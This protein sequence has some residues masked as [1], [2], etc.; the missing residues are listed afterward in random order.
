MP[1][2]FPFEA[3]VDEEIG[4][5][6]TRAMRRVGLR[7]TEFVRWHLNL[8]PE[9]LT[10][11]GNL[12]PHVAKLLESTPRNVLQA[13]TLIPYGTAGL[14]AKLSSRLTIDLTIGRIPEV[15]VPLG[16][17][18]LRWCEVC[19]S[20]ELENYGESYWHRS[21]LLPGVSTCSI[22]GTT[23]LQH[24]GHYST[25]PIHSAAGYWIG[26][27]LPHE[28]MGSPLNFLVPPSLLHQVSHLS[29]RALKGRR[30][31]PLVTPLPAEWRTIFDAGFLQ[32]AGCSSNSVNHAPSTIAGIL[33]HITNRR[34]LK[35]RMGT[36]LEFLL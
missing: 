3:Y 27:A 5:L 1:R 17:L 31:F 6:L 24:L 9:P 15:S 32:F 33:T 34:L 11:I 30:A 8:E 12:I 13:H 14:T 19:L 25:V 29:S 26:E 22:H 10:A 18:G 16:K 20:T 23:L 7:P 21:H 35:S 4:S 28:L 36:Q 2:Y